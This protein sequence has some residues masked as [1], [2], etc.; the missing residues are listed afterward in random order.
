MIIQSLPGSGIEISSVKD[1]WEF[2]VC[3]D[4][5]VAVFFSSPR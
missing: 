1:G 5:D 4:N 3:L 2:C